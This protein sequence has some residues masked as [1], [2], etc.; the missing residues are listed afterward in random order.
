MPD[1]GLA[2]GDQMTASSLAEP[3]SSSATAAR[4]KP[5][6]TVTDPVCG[7]TVDPGTAKYHIAH[8][9]QTYSFCSAVCQSK[10]VNDPA[11]YLAPKSIAATPLFEPTIYTCP[12]H[13][14]FR[15]IGPGACP[16]CGM[17]LEPAVVTAQGGPNHE[18]AGMTR[19][20]GSGWP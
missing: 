19:R 8:G 18:L 13:T 2:D 11:R 15:Q 17:A 12:M 6:Q 5:S 3:A 14:Q 7:M 9:G 20:L 16:I 4:F 1:R 10:F